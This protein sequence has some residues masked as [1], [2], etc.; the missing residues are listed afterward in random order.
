[1]A[2]ARCAGS[3]ILT[4]TNTIRECLL[5]APRCFV[6]RR[7]LLFVV[8]SLRGGADAMR[9]EGHLKAPGPQNLLAFGLAEVLSKLCRKSMG[10]WPSQPR[11]LLSS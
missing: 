7:D 4:N 3:P 1:M 9:K 10:P 5:D 6:A 11:R 8:R 2:T